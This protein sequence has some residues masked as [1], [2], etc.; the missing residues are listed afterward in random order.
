MCNS[1]ALLY[2]FGQLFHIFSSTGYGDELCWSAAWLYRATWEAGYLADAE[3]F[4]DQFDVG[5]LPWAFSWDAKA[6]GA[7][8]RLTTSQ[9]SVILEF[10][11]EVKGD[12]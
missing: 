1:M 9:I 6:A 4:Y 8:V 12:E 3:G 11:I 5:K 10:D 7:Q 2:D